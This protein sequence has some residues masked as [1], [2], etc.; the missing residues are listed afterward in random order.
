[1][2]SKPACRLLLLTLIVILLTGCVTSPDVTTGGKKPSVPVLGETNPRETTVE[3]NNSEIRCQ[4]IPETVENP[5]GIP[6]LKWVCLETSRSNFSEFSQDAV[7]QINRILEGKEMPFRLQ[8]VLYSTE[9]M[10]DADWFSIPEIQE[11]VA[12][13][14]LIYGKFT[15]NQATQYLMP[16]TAHTEGN[17][18]PPLVDAVP[19]AVYWTC[20]DFGGE[21]YGIPTKY[22]SPLSYGYSVNDILL[23]D[24]GLT[25]EEFA[26]PYWEMDELFAR[27]YEQNGS[28]AFLYDP[29]GDYEII[30]DPV[31]GVQS[32]KGSTSVFT[33]G[34]VH[35]P[36]SFYLPIMHHFQLIGSCFAVDF[37]SG[38]PTV[39]NYLETEFVR[40][41]QAA[42]LR[43]R[44]AGYLTEA[45]ASALIRYSF[46]YS[47]SVYHDETNY[48]IP[49]DQLR[50]TATSANPLIGIASASEHSEETLMLLSLMANDEAFRELLL[51]GVERQDYTL[52]ETGS[53]AT[54]VRSNGSSYDMSFLSPYSDLY[55]TGSDFLIPVQEGE[56][57]LDSHRRILDN[58]VVNCD[59]HFDFSPVTSEVEAVNAI[60]TRQQRENF[61]TDPPI[62]FAAFGNLAEAEYDQMLSEIKAAGGDRI[63]AELQRQLDAWLAANPDWNK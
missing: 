20:S 29:V 19:H 14:D 24:W 46:A 31:T 60:L 1:M 40:L 56:T 42:M 59:I 37:S 7:Y 22:H 30:T 8:F 2:K 11:A 63:Q 21:I 17:A 28:K 55:G 5:D 34:G 33:Y 52:T 23:E 51:F 38:T 9:S 4:Y 36:A 32:G 44:K 35:I 50:W 13:A 16:L 3:K 15:E 47:D 41:S 25:A 6:V 57:R 53:H 58:A 12:E 43:Y 45:E 48:L 39:V 61:E 62:Q 26:V 10:E 49:A 27:I 18:T 54:I